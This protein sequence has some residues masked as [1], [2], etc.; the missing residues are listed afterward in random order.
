MWLSSL[1]AAHYYNVPQAQLLDMDLSTA[2]PLDAAGSAASVT[3]ALSTTEGEVI[4][5]GA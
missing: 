4:F 1:K 2:A 5:S 3:L